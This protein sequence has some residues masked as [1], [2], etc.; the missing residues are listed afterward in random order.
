L[1]RPK[2]DHYDEGA[3]I[4]Y[5]DNETTRRYRDELRAINDWLAAADITFDAA[6]HE[7]PV[8]TGAR[9]LYR[10]FTLGRFDRGGRLFGGFWEN[11]P[12]PVRLRGLT[13]EGEYVIGLDYAQLN[14]TLAYAL[15]KAQPPAGDAY[16]LPGLKG[17]REGVKK[18]FNAML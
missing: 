11:F 17:Y 9:R 7:R 15:A 1:K 3:R 6:S 4:E 14:P 18:V 2:R 13:I 5:D 10:P 8:N 12:N 16:A